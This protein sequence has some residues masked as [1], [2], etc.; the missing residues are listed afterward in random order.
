MTFRRIA[1]AISLTTVLLGPPLVARASTTTA[2]VNKA[3]VEHAMNAL[4]VQ[5]DLSAL[6]R[7]WGGHPYIQHNPHIDNGIEA[8][9]KL[10]RRLP[11]HFRYVPGMV[12]AEGNL[13][14]MHGL[15]IG[16]GPK[17]L[18]AVDIFRIRHG[19]IV[20]HWDVMQPEV[21]PTETA[22]GN[23]MFAPGH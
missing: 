14:M 16:F 9:A 13:V 20:E 22:S 18:V 3:L 1:F 10:V 12:V 5:R 6:K 4:F 23:P 8:L 7:Y 15:Y 2:E 11:A 17:P 19:R 21:P